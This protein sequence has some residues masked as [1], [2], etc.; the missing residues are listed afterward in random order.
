M[1][2][3]CQCSSCAFYICS[4]TVLHCAA[5]YIED[6]TVNVTMIKNPVSARKEGCLTGS[7]VYQA[8][9]GYWSFYAVEYN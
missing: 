4:V 6:I 7:K 5:E 3:I 2:L 8:Q 1:I 9:V